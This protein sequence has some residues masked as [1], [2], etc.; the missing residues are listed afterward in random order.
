MF[1][2]RKWQVL[3]STGGLN[4]FYSYPKSGKIMKGDI[5][6]GSEYS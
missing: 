5:H 2:G 1:K 6:R 3:M 4:G